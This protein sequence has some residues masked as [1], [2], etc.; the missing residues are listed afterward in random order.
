MKMWGLPTWKLKPEGIFWKLWCK[1]L[2][3][4]SFKWGLQW[5]YT[6]RV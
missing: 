5:K 4:K 1:R 3:T 6:Q 2:T